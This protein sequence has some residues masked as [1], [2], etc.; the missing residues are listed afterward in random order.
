MSVLTHGGSVFSYGCT[1]AA[2]FRGND[3]DAV[4][5]RT[6]SPADV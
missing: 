2:S 6:H 5:T 1:Y 3:V 4:T